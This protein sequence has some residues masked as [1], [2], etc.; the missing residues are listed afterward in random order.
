MDLEKG[1]QSEQTLGSS[2]LSGKNT[3][4]NYKVQGVSRTGRG[5]GNSGAGT[6]FGLRK[7]RVGSG[8]AVHSLSTQGSITGGGLTEMQIRRVFLKNQGD[9]NYC[10]ERSLVT[11]INCRKYKSQL[12]YS[13]K[14]KRG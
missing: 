5:S 10:Y 13:T 14:W 11:E 1:H 8:K 2:G 9:L 3:S 7:G 6:G 12:Y 4:K